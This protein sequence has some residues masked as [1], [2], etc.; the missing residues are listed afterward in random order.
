MRR[1]CRGHASCWSQVVMPCCHV[2]STGT[3]RN[4]TPVHCSVKAHGLQ[5]DKCFTTGPLQNL[6]FFLSSTSLAPYLVSSLPWPSSRDKAWCPLRA[7]GQRESTREAVTLTVTSAG[8]R[9]S[10]SMLLPQT[11]HNKRVG[12]APQPLGRRPVC[13]EAATSWDA[14]H[15]RASCS[16][17]LHLRWWSGPSKR[18]RCRRRHSE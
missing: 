12:A 7:S 13:A 11:P 2:D 14:W 16:S 8:F 5:Q 1:A 10:N 15:K 6:S 4:S 3:C 18:R 9:G 17:L